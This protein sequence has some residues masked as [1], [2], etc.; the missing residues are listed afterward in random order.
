MKDYRRCRNCLFFRYTE[1]GSD[2]ECRR[3][4]PVLVYYWDAEADEPE[5]DSAWPV[6]QEHEDC[7][8]WQ[9]RSEKDYAE[10]LQKEGKDQNEASEKT[11]NK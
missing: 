8:E 10:H 4:P 9:P 1:P 6:V 2:G 5:F 7:G 3:N 11:D